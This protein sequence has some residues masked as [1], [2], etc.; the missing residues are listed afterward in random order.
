MNEYLSAIISTAV[1]C[2][3]VSLFA[4]ERGMGR[5]VKYIAALAVISVMLSPLVS[6]LADIPSFSELMNMQDYASKSESDF[7]SAVIGEVKKG[8][9]QSVADMLESRFK[10]SRGAVR[11]EFILD[12][13][14]IE[15]V[16]IERIDIWIY[17]RVN[18][19]EISDISR[20]I[21]DI[22]GCGVRV[23]GDDDINNFNGG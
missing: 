12:T 9:S 15:N 14:D 19:L 10:I 20:Y 2:G 6:V 21:G 23:Y 7:E 13:G 1:A 17:P 11:S 3:I 18:A 5:Y 4:G 8:L 22:F 16:V